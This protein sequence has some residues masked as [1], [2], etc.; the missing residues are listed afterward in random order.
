[1]STEKDPQCDENI[2]ENSFRAC[3]KVLVIGYSAGANVAINTGGVFAKKKDSSRMNDVVAGVM[4]IG[5]PYGTLGNSWIL[6]FVGTWD[7]WDAHG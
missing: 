1:M 7:S 4:A 2:I 6:V 3:K 5:G